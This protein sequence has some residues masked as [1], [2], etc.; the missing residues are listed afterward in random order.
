M[1]FKYSNSVFRIVFCKS[2]IT[3]FLNLMLEEKVW[4]VIC[5]Y[6]VGILS[7]DLY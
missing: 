4:L 6:S 1:A 5:L 3:H 2:D 7:D